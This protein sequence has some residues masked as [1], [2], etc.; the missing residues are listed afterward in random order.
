MAY[1]VV[2]C[3]LLIV[4]LLLSFYRKDVPV[5][6]L[7]GKYFT[8]ES[9]YIEVDDARLHVRITGTGVPLF[10][11]HGSFA[12][13]HTWNAWQNELS[14]FFKTISLD[15]PGH[16]LSGPN[17]NEI[18]TSD[19]YASLVFA[20]ADS[21]KIDS[22][23]IAGN[24]MGGNVAWKIA[25]MQPE[26]VKKIILIDASGFW[27]APVKTD[28]ALVDSNTKRPL[29]F[30]LLS[31]DKL[32]KTLSSITPRFLFRLN[33]QQVYGDPANI[34]DEEVDRYYDLMLRE[35]N[36]NATLTRL[37]Q[38]N[39]NLQDSIKYIKNPTLILWGE[40]DTWIPV[41]HAYRF[42]NAIEH[43]TLIIFPDAGHVPME[44]IPEESLKHVI[45]FLLN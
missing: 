37:R 11:L 33:L 36:R 18:Y 7:E 25:L 15:L 45:P 44:E 21:L 41:T 23:H 28:S 13:L 39:K 35:G 2:F 14:K 32:A 20:L 34:S 27:T 16:G 22:F 12:S 26:R 9:K 1:A 30:R 31:S 8:E 24:S 3:I 6:K 29:I 10:L 17:K 5:N 19:Y 43:S 38:A 4:V 42:N 40:K